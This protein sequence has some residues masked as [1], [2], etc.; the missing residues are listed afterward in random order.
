MIIAFAYRIAYTQIYLL[1]GDTTLYDSSSGSIKERDK[2]N[3]RTVQRSLSSQQTLHSSEASVLPSVYAVMNTLALDPPVDTE[4]CLS[5]LKTIEQ[6]D[7][8][9]PVRLIDLV[10]V[11][12][13]GRQTKLVG[14][15]DPEVDI[16]I[17]ALTPREV[18]MRTFG[19]L[20]GEA[21]MEILE[22]LL[23]QVTVVRCEA[24]HILEYCQVAGD[25]C[26]DWIM[27]NESESHR[28]D[29]NSL[30]ITVDRLVEMKV[31]IGLALATGV[32]NLGELALWHA[33]G[34]D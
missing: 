3:S 29:E 10:G 18:P 2:R 24:D 8:I 16:K 4:H 33:V 21:A 11:V 28:N 32:E 22:D 1:R 6:S 25:L 7:K 31:G 15:E 9:R 27:L 14:N 12:C 30:A 19:A 26:E 17:L 23:N 20:S 13:L 5:W 34:I